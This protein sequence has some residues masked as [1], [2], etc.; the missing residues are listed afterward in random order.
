MNKEKII[1]GLHRARA[2]I[3]A[4]PENVATTYLTGDIDSDGRVELR[5]YPK[6]TQEEVRNWSA[7]LGTFEKDLENDTYFRM[8]QRQENFSVRVTFKKELVCERRVVGT[9][10]VPDNFTPGRLE[11]AHEEDIVE[12]DCK[13]ILAPEED[14]VPEE[15]KEEK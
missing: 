5:F 8:V 15:Q 11:P 9:K 4:L 7:A 12:W 6:N 10:L 14:A 1:E 13:S 2:F 3:A